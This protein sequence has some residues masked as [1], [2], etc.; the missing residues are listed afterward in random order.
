M[1]GSCD[2][3]DVYYMHYSVNENYT[4]FDR[5]RTESPK[6]IRTSGSRKH[7]GIQCINAG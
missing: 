5:I 2:D 7:T 3:W 4:L 6:L 1:E